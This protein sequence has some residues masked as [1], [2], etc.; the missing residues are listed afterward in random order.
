MII[1]TM[2][3]SVSVTI[4]STKNVNEAFDNSSIVLNIMHEMSEAFGGCTMTKAYGAYVADNGALITE[5]V[6]VIS[7]FVSEEQFFCAYTTMQG[8]AQLVCRVMTQECVLFTV[9][10]V[11]FLVDGK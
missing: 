2:P 5:E 4:P 9:D 7:A 1:A 11:A 6:N 10:N 3:H 8:I